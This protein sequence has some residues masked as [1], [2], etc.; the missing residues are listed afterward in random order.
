MFRLTFRLT[1]D[2]LRAM[3]CITP[4]IS[5]SIPFSLRSN[6]EHSIYLEHTWEKRPREFTF[7][8]YSVNTLEKSLPNLMFLV[9]PNLGIKNITKGSYL[10]THL[11]PAMQLSR[12]V[13]PFD[14]S[15]LLLRLSSTLAVASLQA[16]PSRRCFKARKNPNNRR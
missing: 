11:T 15:A 6:L 8:D 12:T 7:I 10:E 9:R 3:P 2:L 16:R 5:A 13:A 14:P 4:D 1:I